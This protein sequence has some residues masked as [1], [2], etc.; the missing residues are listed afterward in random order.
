M[1][2]LRHNF[3]RDELKAKRLEEIY[4]VLEVGCVF[5]TRIAS[6]TSTTYEVEWLQS[7]VCR[8]WDVVPPPGLSKKQA[9]AK[10]IRNSLR[11]TNAK[12]CVLRQDCLRSERQRS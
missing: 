12:M 3:P 9:I 8:Y 10:L 7:T 1:C 11:R 6:E 2:V 4:G 5:S